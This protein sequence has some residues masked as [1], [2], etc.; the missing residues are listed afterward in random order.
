[1]VFSSFTFLL[2]FLP[3][4]LAGYYLINTKL[5][6]IFLLIMSLAF[7]AWGDV[8]SLPILAGSIAANY[9]F[10]LLIDKFKEKK[11]I[12]KLLMIIAAVCN[13]GLLCAFKYLTFAVNNINLIPG[14][15]ITAPEWAM[16]LGISFFTFSALSYILDVYFQ[17]VSAEKNILNTA[18]YISFFPKL[19]SGPIVKWSSFEAQIR[20]RK[21][22]V[23]MMTDG[24]KRFIVGLGKKVII[25]DTI[26]V[27][28]DM[29][30]DNTEFSGVSVVMAWT[31]VICYLIQLYFDFSGYSDM[32]VGIGKMFGFTL[33]ENFDYPY[34]AK[35]AAD[36]W[37]RWHITLGTWVKHYIYTPVFRAISK[38]KNKKT[39]KK[40]SMK[41]C[42]YCGLIVTWLIIGI[43]HG[44]GYK[45]IV[46]GMYYCF[47]I[48]MER[49]FDNY[50]KKRAKSDKPIKMNYF[51]EHILPH[52]YLFF[53]ICFGQMLFRSNSLTL[54]FEHLKA[55]LGLAGN[56]FA[57][58]A[59]LYW[60]GENL[61]LIIIG[62]VLSLPVVPYIKAHLKNG[63]VQNVYAIAETVILAAVLI[64]SV[65][66]ISIT[67]YDPFIYFNF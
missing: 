48:I 66:F 14:I 4:C 11:A 63:A 67:S 59:S 50:K 42:D 8:R 40:F 36:F 2:I 1:M 6:N 27:I 16:P 37:A 15:N 65:C 26:G 25:S 18:L 38:K 34:A 21:F 62:V 12:A 5:R 58:P 13:V 24:V 7:Y 41:T 29:V 32:A 33:D 49:A 30:F 45:F 3:I 9:V 43:W 39:G 10:A 54:S 64:M 17:S 46:Y 60:V 47:F 56:S 55:M 23:D 53:V 61:V 51:T 28:A 31:G 52:I 44:A 19:I 35:T 22:S 20:E 57:D